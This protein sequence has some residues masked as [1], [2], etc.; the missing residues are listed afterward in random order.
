MRIRPA[1]WYPYS[2]P[3]VSGLN[4]IRNSV[5]VVVDAFNGTVDLYIIDES[6]PIIR[7]WAKIFPDLFRPEAEF[8]ADLRAHWRYPQ[9][10]FQVQAEQYLTYHIVEASTL[11]NREDMWAVPQEVLRKQTVPLEP[12]YVTLRL[13]D[14]AE[15]EFL[16]ILPLTPR[17]RQNAISW[18]AG[19]SD[20]ENFGELFAFR[21]PAGAERGGAGADRGADRPGAGGEH[22]VHAAGAGR[23]R[24]GA[25]GICCSFRWGI[26]TSTWSRSTC[27]RRRRAFRS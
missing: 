1:N 3:H 6:D 16:L 10:L 8:P 25:G 2:Q 22:A 18:L 20:G 15:P 7:V 17:N 13:P 14:G 23:Q 26:R 24:G 9:D 21:F 5:K 12:Y 19:R 11:F 27:R 4:Y